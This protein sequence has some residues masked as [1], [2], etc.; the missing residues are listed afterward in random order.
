MGH[1]GK[2]SPQ[3]LHIY[4]EVR[5]DM[6]YGRML[7]GKRAFITTGARG[8]GKEIALLFAKHGA[9]VAV[10]GRNLP[11]LRKPKRSL[12]NH[13]PGQKDMV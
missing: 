13:P 6:D 5:T 1:A 4:T 11:K 3:G 9:V 2:C 10:G 12:R 7:T 8:I